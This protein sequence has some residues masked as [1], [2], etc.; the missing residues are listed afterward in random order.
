MNTVKTSKAKGLSTYAYDFK[1]GKK[2]LTK[3]GTMRVTNTKTF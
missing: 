1:K 3:F 2:K